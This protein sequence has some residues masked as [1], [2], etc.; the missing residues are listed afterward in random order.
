[1]NILSLVVLIVLNS[2]FIYLVD[3]YQA[4]FV[5]FFLG[6]IM[7][8]TFDACCFFVLLFKVHGTTIDFH[9]F[10]LMAVTYGRSGKKGTSPPPMLFH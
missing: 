6:S 7:A 1:M 3:V 10:I 9:F 8:H 5:Y 2:F 4:I